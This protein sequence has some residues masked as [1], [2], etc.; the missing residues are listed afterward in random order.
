M[1]FAIPH[2]NG[3]PQNHRSEYSDSLKL[4]FLKYCALFSGFKRYTNMHLQMQ[5]K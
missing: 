4:A 5:M 3:L 1:I 2:I